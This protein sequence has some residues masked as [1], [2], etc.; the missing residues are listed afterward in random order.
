MLL[1]D[2][3]PDRSVIHDEFLR[4]H[5]STTIISVITAFC[6]TLDVRS[7]GEV[8]GRFRSQ[9]APLEAARIAGRHHGMCLSTFGFGYA[10]NSVCLPAV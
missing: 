1:T 3:E 8:L 9:I 6:N 4:N 2:G 5:L 10:M 7:S